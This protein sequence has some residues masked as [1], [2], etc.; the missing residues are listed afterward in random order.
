MSSA[1][2]RGESRRDGGGCHVPRGSRGFSAIPYT[3]ALAGAEVILDRAAVSAGMHVLDAGSGPGRVAIP[4][5]QRI[6]PEGVVVA[7][8]LQ[9]RMLARVRAGAVQ[10]GLRNVVTVAGSIDAGFRC[11]G[12][13]DRALLIA[14]LSEIPD[15]LGAMR[16]LHNTPRFGGLHSVTEMIQDPHYQT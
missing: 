9:E 11:A 6:G 13:F 1:L 5:A 8:K 12:D 7:M 16:A 2:S 4:V 14:V 10:R 15:R 3:S